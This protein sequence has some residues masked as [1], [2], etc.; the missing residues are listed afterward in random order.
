MGMKAQSDTLP[1][2]TA[3]RLKTTATLVVAVGA[4]V[5]G[6][7][8]TLAPVTIVVD[9]A[10]QIFHTHQDT[11]GGAL[12]HAGLFLHPE[13]RI[14]HGQPVEGSPLGVPLDPNLPIEIERAR[15]VTIAADGHTVPVRTHAPSVDGVLLEASVSLL[16]GDDLSVHG[17][18][19]PNGI[20]GDPPEP[21]RVVIQRAVPFTIHEDGQ[22]SIH[23]TTATTVGEALQQAGITL[24][25]ADGVSPGLGEPMLAGLHVRL[26]RSVP[27]T[28]RVD[29]HTLTTR[30][31]RQRVDE[32]L[33]QLGVILAGRDRTDPPLNATIDEDT[34]GVEVVRVTERLLIEQEPIPYEALWQ[35][36]PDLELDQIVYVQAGEPG[37]LERRTRVVY[38]DGRQISRE[39]EQEYVALAPQPSIQSY[40]TRIVTRTMETPYGTIEY[41]RKIRMLATSYSKSTAGTP[42]DHPWYGWTR[43]GLPM[44]HGIVAID[45]DIIALMSDVYV[46]GYGPGLAADT[47]GVILG[48]R[49]DLGYDDDNLV[50]WLKWV[51]VYVLTPVPPADEI[52]YILPPL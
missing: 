43:S 10:E 28:V 4:V 42:V 35:P 1:S 24:Y 36:N 34:P 15:L 30:S 22:A 5:A 38:E 41:W 8:S 23:R 7:V 50:L 20:P 12:L 11:V 27:I 16:P 29:G 18:F 32:L 37:V 46:P 17:E 31:L 14:F 51:D 2:R 47:G 19:L 48:R 33:A 21:V 6:Y 52:N 3:N 9:G 49:I 40:G 45:P 26:D 39:T 13:D 25:L 44:R